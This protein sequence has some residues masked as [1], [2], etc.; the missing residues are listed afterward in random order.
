M[1]DNY[2][3]TCQLIKSGLFSTHVP[4][5]T[6]D[7]PNVRLVPIPLIEKNLNKLVK[8]SDDDERREIV[9]FVS[10]SDGEAYQADT[11][12]RREEGTGT[13]LLEAPEFSVWLNRNK[14]T[15]F[16]HVI[17]GAGKTIL[18]SIVNDYLQRKFGDEPSVGVAYVF[19]DYRQQNFQTANIL[20]ASLLR[21]LLQKIPLIPEHIKNLYFKYRDAKR[22]LQLKD[23]CQCLDVVIGDFSKVHIVI[24]ALDECDWEARHYLLKQIFDLQSK[25]NLGFFAT[26]RPIPEV[27]SRFEDCQS[28]EI[29]AH[30][31][32]V[33]TYL[34]GQIVRLP[35]FVRKNRSLLEFVTKRIIEATEGM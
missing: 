24:D 34:S 30:I 1:P 8:R 28:L 25:H 16:C 35:V 5:H 14:H 23:L 22:R 33:K 29:R 15:L 13:W 10:M 18:S 32:D 20:L 27:T 9:D 19:C 7:L 12:S 31:E 3:F 17:P 11:F 2:V 21:Q 26:L 4:N 6:L